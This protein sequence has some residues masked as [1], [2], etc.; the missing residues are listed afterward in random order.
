MFKSLS[1]PVH[2]DQQPTFLFK[3]EKRSAATKNANKRFLT[4]VKNDQYKIN[5]SDSL[6]EKLYLNH[7]GTLN[8]N[9]TI[10]SSMNENAQADFNDT[11]PL[12]KKFPN[13][14]HQFPRKVDDEVI[15]ET[16][17]VID[18]LLNG[19]V[20]SETVEYM[21][22][23]PNNVVS[24]T[25]SKTIQV[26]TLQTDPLLPP[27]F[28]LKKNRHRP[29]SPPPPVLKATS[30][31]KL[32]KE[33]KDYWNIPS[34]ISNW[35]NNQG[36]TIALDKRATELTDTP[37]V[38]LEGFASLS[39]ALD[40]ADK[41]ARQEIKIRNDMLKQKAIQDAEE[42]ELKL[43]QLIDITRRE[44]Q[45]RNDRKRSYNNYDDNKRRR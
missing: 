35:K 7:D 14:V 21:D 24:K 2:T 11:I 33:E 34:A 16:K 30:T 15:Q 3:N 40:N 45:E 36:F 20:V 4:L 37:E 18:K 12:K 41:Q 5:D 10:A 39:Q 31:E 43:K 25:E 6:I 1:K 32:T 19:D 8:Y 9:K 28:K 13:L 44:R 17:A 38:N 23:Q 29:P 26:H 42:K 27:K 22:Y